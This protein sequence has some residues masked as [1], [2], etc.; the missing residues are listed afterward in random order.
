M[1]QGLNWTRKVQ[2]SERITLYRFSY[3][4]VVIDQQV[5]S[6]STRLVFRKVKIVVLDINKWRNNTYNVTY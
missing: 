2:V 6:N 3:S 4:V 5:V 1:L